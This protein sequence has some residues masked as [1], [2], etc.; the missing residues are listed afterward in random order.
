MVPSTVI[1]T[2][3]DR[4]FVTYRMMNLLKRDKGKRLKCM[5]LISHGI[6]IPLNFMRD[7]TVP[8]GELSA[9]NRNRAAYL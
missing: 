3:P 4:L 9:W 8:M 2:A 7:Y 6:A 5:D 1:E